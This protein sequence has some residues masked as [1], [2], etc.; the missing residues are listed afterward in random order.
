MSTVFIPLLVY[1]LTKTENKFP[2]FFEF[3][4]NSNYVSFT[5]RATNT[6]FFY[7]HHQK[8]QKNEEMFCFKKSFKN[9]RQK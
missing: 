6:K 7:H 4:T 9:R 3:L 2:H 5:I 1:L 8:S